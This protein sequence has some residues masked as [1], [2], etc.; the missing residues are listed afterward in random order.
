MMSRLS[1]STAV[2]CRCGDRRRPW[3]HALLWG[4]AACMSVAAAPQYAQAAVIDQSGGGVFTPFYHSVSEAP[5]VGQEFIPTIEDH[6]GVHLWFGESAGQQV[7]L[8]L[9]IRETSIDGNV[10]LGS[11]VNQSLVIARPPADPGTIYPGWRPAVRVDFMFDDVIGLTS[12]S[13]YVIELQCEQS[14]CCWAMTWNM[15]QE[16]GERAIFEG[17]PQSQR[18]FS[19]TTLVV[20]EPLSAML[21]L[22]GSLVLRLPGRRG[23]RP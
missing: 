13:R 9:R 7:D 10:V 22:A 11:I 1:G 23:E 21:L 18:E 20:P 15:H 12:G 4:M 8:T 3:T 2:F 19:F 6:I 16:I 14:I 17:Q 5:P